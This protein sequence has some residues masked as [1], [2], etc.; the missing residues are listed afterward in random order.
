MTHRDRILLNA[1]LRTEFTAFSQRCFSTLNPGATFLPNWHIEALAYHLELVRMGKIRRLIVNMPPRSLKSII[2]SVAFPAFVLG[3]DP[4]KRLVVVS[5]G[6]ELAVKLANDCRIILQSPWFQRLFPGTRVSRIK[7]TEFEVATTRQGYRLATSVGGALT[8]RGGDLIIIDDPMKPQDALSGTKRES[9]NDWFDNTLLSRLD[10]K[11]TGAIIV[12]MQR[13][14][15]DDLT[16]KLL[17]GSDDWT[18][19]NF[20][21]IAEQDEQIQIGEVR[22]HIRK[23]GDLLHS[24]REPMQV[25]NYMRAQL[26]PE[27]FAAQYQQNPVP[28]GGN[29]IKRHWPRRYDKL[30]DR[31]SSTE[32]LQSYDTASKIGAEN[33]WSVCTTWHVIDER[34]YLIDVLRGRFDYP[35][36]KARAIEHAKL[37]RPTKILV[38]DTGVGTALVPELQNCGFSVIAVPVEQNKQTRMSVQS[39]K[40][41]SGRV[42]LP[43]HATWLEELES[44]LF[45][46]PG[47]RYDDQVDSI[48]QALGHEIER[49]FWDAKSVE[50]LGRLTEALVMDRYFAMLT[51]RPW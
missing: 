27:V 46:F 21:A 30:P 8:G 42:F 23:V 36:L 6:T 32:V 43:H 41:E 19:L 18:V 45:A 13:L 4:A 1:I 51:G 16:G 47:S 24:E 14:H 2:C 17:R 22:Y 25:L 50:G 20:P 11:Q 48:S 44:E 10:D 15:V 39:A 31:T 26:G 28:P 49:P 9:A 38:E 40:F 12:V 34:Y 5:Y 33:D 29:M 37:H 3:H 7:N 35:T